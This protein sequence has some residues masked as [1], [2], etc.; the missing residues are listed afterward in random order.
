MGL[1]ASAPAWPVPPEQSGEV[2]L[3]STAVST[4]AVTLDLLSG[5]E[6]PSRRARSLN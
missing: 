6:G 5:F 3:R 4:N 1:V 2:D